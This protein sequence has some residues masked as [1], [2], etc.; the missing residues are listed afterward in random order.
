MRFLL[1]LIAAAVAAAVPLAFAAEPITAVPAASA[2]RPNVAKSHDLWGTI[3]VCDTEAHPNTIGVRGSMPGLGYRRSILWMRFQIQYF[4][5]ADGE[6]HNIRED[7]DS[8]WKKLGLARKRVIESGHN[9]MFLPPPD[10]G[11]HNLR[12]AVTF[13]WTARGKLIKKLR[14]ITEPGHKSTAGS[15]P[16]GFS[17]GICAIS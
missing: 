9:F 6:W 2:K 16:P 7:A 15:D 17:A 8:G 14:E 3:N 10:G 1:P 4:A 12:G 5:R 13:K 11:A